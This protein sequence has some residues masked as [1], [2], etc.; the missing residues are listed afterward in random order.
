MHTQIL[1][2]RFFSVRNSKMFKFLT[3]FSPIIKRA[4]WFTGNLSIKYG[5]NGPTMIAEG[6]R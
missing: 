4:P 3:D 2:Y 6:Q 5:P 1:S